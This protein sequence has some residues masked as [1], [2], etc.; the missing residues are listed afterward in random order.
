[1]WV[2]GV[3]QPAGKDSTKLSPAIWGQLQRGQKP[4]TA[5]GPRHRQLLARVEPLTFSLT[6]GKLGRAVGMDAGSKPGT[7]QVWATLGWPSQPQGSG[8]RWPCWN[9]RFSEDLLRA[10]PG[11]ALARAHVSAARH[12]LGGRCVIAPI[13]PKSKQRLREGSWVSSATQREARSSAR[14]LSRP[15]PKHA[16]PSA[17]QH[18]PGAGSP[19]KQLCCNVRDLSSVLPG[20]QAA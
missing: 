7:S 4:R 17:G 18:P 15:T 8:N 19:G 11:C 9:S 5:H 16:S 1:M 3:R 12:S 13:L 2:T 14:T 10:G 6:P 20:T